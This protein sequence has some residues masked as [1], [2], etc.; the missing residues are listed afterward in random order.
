MRTRQHHQ[1]PL[2]QT[3]SIIST[4]YSQETFNQWNNQILREAD[5]AVETSTSISTR[6]NTDHEEHSLLETDL[7]DK[8]WPELLC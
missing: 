1:A 5:K 7:E 6:I 8:D 2:H 3:T 4:I